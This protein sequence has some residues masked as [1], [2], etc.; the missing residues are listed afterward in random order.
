MG[1]GSQ[2]QDIWRTSILN[3]WSLIHSNPLLPLTNNAYAQYKCKMR[4]SSFF[5]LCSSRILLSSLGFLVLWE[6][7]M[8]I[9][10]H[11]REGYF[12]QSSIKRSH[13]KNQQG[14]GADAEAWRMLL[15]SL[16]LMT[17]SVGYL[18][19]SGPPVQCGRSLQAN[20]M[21]VFSWLRFL[22]RWANLMLSWHTNSQHTE[23]IHPLSKIHTEKASKI[24][25]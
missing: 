8:T 6:N 20:P 18:I 9:S 4:V 12:T 23:K 24:P 13:C 11:R 1:A 19:Q 16:F 14:R 17:C 2:T 15:P 21:E 10:K 25:I 22:P 7:T 5:L 3:H